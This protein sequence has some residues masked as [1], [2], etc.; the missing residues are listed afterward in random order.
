CVLWASTPGGQTR[1]HRTGGVISAGAG[2]RRRSDNHPGCM[3]A[4][5]PQ[6]PDFIKRFLTERSAAAVEHQPQLDTIATRWLYRRLQHCAESLT[7]AVDHWDVAVDARQ[8]AK[9]AG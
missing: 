2:S 9:D 1:S 3:A 8:S 7:V 5:P 4:D 6:D